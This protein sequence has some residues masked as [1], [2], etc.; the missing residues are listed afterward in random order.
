[1]QRPAGVTIIAVLG[2]IAGAALALMGLALCM[3]GAMFSGMAHR[4]LGMMIGMGGA[5]VGIVLLGIA[6]LYIITSIGL[7]KLQE[8]AR[9]LAIVLTAVG[10]LV[11][12]LG[13]F[14]VFR[15]PHVMFFFGVF[16][17]H[18]VMV[19]IDVWIIIYL[20]QPNVQ[21]AFGAT[22]AGPAGS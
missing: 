10:L 8:W 2:I 11:S 9:V 13:L 16:I 22:S 18:V 7:L 17:R 19:A 1:M 5:V 3:G 20:L 14:D 12:G 15:H 6:A 4:P 21:R